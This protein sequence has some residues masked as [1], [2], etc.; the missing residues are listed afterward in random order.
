[1]DGEEDGMGVRDRVLEA[2]DQEPEYPGEMPDE[3]R[4]AMVNAMRYGDLDFVAE[5]LR[6][7]VRLAKAGI[8]ARVSRV[9][10]KEGLG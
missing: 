2:V 5:A 7:T 6:L 8:R 4:E 1:M 9:L 3:M 10:E